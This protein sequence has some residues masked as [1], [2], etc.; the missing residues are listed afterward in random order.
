[1]LN[2]I[3]NEIVEDA[4]ELVLRSGFNIL[5]HQP[6]DIRDK[7]LY[8]MFGSKFN[9]YLTQQDNITLSENLRVSY[10]HVFHLS[11][12]AADKEMRQRFGQ[13]DLLV[14]DLSMA[15]NW[16]KP[17][18]PL[19]IPYLFYFMD[20]EKSFEAALNLIYDEKIMNYT[21]DDISMYF[22]NFQI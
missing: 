3:Y 18:K 19:H 13:S 5:M 12:I 6:V 9:A 7:D 8:N 10:V 4:F 17:L 1:M 2:P 22:N 14:E 21:S 11:K 20:T 16:P 15:T